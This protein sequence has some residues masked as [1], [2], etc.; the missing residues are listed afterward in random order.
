MPPTTPSYPPEFRREAVELVRI[1]GKPIR[2]IAKDLDSGTAAVP[3]GRALLHSGVRASV[4]SSLTGH[5]AVELAMAIGS[6]E[7]R[8]P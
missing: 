4:G 1:S 6:S 3:R 5:C 2:Q 8:A 7:D